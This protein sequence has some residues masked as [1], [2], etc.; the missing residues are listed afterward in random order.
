MSVKSRRSNSELDGLYLF[1]AE[2]FHRELDEKMLGMLR[3]E[4]VLGVLSSL[5]AE[6]EEYVTRSWGAAEYEEAAV[7]FCDY[8]ILESDSAPRAAAW[9][10][11]GGE[12]TPEAVDAVMHEYL[13]QW[14]MELPPTYSRLA[15]DHLSLIFYVIVVVRGQ[16]EEQAEALESTIL[17]PWVARFGKVLSGKENPLYRSVGKLLEDL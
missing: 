11:P 2:L 6:C 9:L 8:F 16:D 13:E 14:A 7:Q 5:D 15:Y 1:L 4:D 10:A 3:Q 12:V 17:K